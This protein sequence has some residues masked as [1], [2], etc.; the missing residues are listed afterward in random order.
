MNSDSYSRMYNNSYLERNTLQGPPG[1]KGEKGEI[2]EQGLQGLPGIVGPPGPPGINGQRGPRGLVGE[3]GYPG[4]KGDEGERGKE[5]R[6]GI[7]GEMGQKGY[8]GNTG[9]KGEKGEMGQRGYVGNTGPIGPQGPDGERG[10][11]GIRGEMGYRGLI[12]LQ[13]PTGERGQEGNPGPQGK[14]GTKGDIGPIGPTGMLGPKGDIGSTGTIIT[15]ITGNTSGIIIETNSNKNYQIEWPNNLIINNNSNNTNSN[16]IYGLGY[17]STIVGNSYYKLVNNNPF[18]SQFSINSKKIIPGNNLEYKILLNKD[19]SMDIL[20]QYNNHEEYFKHIKNGMTIRINGH[21][22]ENNVLGNK[23]INQLGEFIITEIDLTNLELNEFI[24]LYCINTKWEYYTN[25]QQNLLINSW[26]Q[27]SIGYL[28]KDGM[29]GP[30][31]YKGLDGLVGSTGKQGL[32]GSTG[33]TGSAIIKDNTISNINTGYWNRIAFTDSNKAL[34][35]FYISNNDTKIIFNAGINKEMNDITI[36]IVGNLIGK[37]TIE[38]IRILYS[39]SN[40]ISYLE[41]YIDNTNLISNNN[42]T[43]ILDSFDNTMHNWTII[44]NEIQYDSIEDLGNKNFISQSLLDNNYISKILDITLT[45]GIITTSSINTNS[46]NINNNNII[47]LENNILTLSKSMYTN[48]YEFS[49]NIF[50][51]NSAILFNCRGNYTYNEIINSNRKPPTNNE[52]SLGSFSSVEPL[53]I[54]SNIDINSLDISNIFSQDKKQLYKDSFIC[55]PYHSSINLLHK[56]EVRNILGNNSNLYVIQKY[57]NNSFNY[58]YQDDIIPDIYKN[59]FD[60]NIPQGICFSGNTGII[61]NISM[62]LIN[63]NIYTNSIPTLNTIYLANNDPD[64]STN[65]N[66]DIIGY[67]SYRIEIHK[68]IGIKPYTNNTRIQYTNWI[69]TN[70]YQYYKDILDSDWNFEENIDTNSYIK[71]FANHGDIISIVFKFVNTNSTQSNQIRNKLIN[72]ITNKTHYFPYNIGVQSLKFS[73]NVQNY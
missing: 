30:T 33:P 67:I 48:N 64:L 73:I 37:N 26:Y 66:Y 3:Q 39:S 71:G 63:D 34:N 6:V 41:Y 29:I 36:N 70:K 16:I 7:K 38:S 57:I 25:N 22:T 55:P 5:G 58:Y 62:N 27:I 46:I 54:D 35:T 1:I 65:I 60:D 56:R 31:G 24:I 9:S 12:G 18:S 2:G 8:I 10:P 49:L 21:T 43:I 14:D 23:N 44:N 45:S 61:R 28:P 40:N 20:G 53:E 47:K 32:I 51:K 42:K 50:E 13:G 15:G 52:F 4:L 72:Q 69:I 68:Y 19:S 59:S 11:P 17:L